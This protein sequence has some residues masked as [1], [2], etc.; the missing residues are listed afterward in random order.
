MKYSPTTLDLA[1]MI[2]DAVLAA[3][4]RRH[5]DNTEDPG[6]QAVLRTLRK[7][8]HWFVRVDPDEGVARS[9]PTERRRRQ[10]S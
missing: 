9:V 7:T 4:P 6:T 5:R 2:A 1:R 10:T 8:R 3:G